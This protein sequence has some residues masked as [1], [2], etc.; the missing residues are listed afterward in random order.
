MLK[1]YFSIT[2][3]GIIYGNAITA[4]AGFLLAS[5][6]NV[7]ILK[8]TATVIGISLVIGSACVFNNILDKEIDKKMERT[9][10]RTLVKGEISDKNAFVYGLILGVIGFLT[11]GISTNNIVVLIGLFAFIDYVILY[12]FSKR[13]SVHGT[14]IGSL[15]GSAPIVAGYCAVSGSIDETALILFAILTAWQM[16]HFY[17]IAIYR[18]NDYKKA[19]IPVLP[20]VRSIKVTKIYIIFYILTFILFTILLRFTGTV[21]NYFFVIITILGLGW[22]LLALSGF[23]KA[24][25]LWSRYMFYYSLM[26]LMIFSIMIS[27]EY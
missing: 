19:N 11:L 13:N 27:F 2:K 8:L 4:I 23:K 25:K 5:K 1:S 18:L 22:L 17:S 20:A 24:K 12:G 14:L 10:N 3:P 9:K 21:N 6:G 7:N 16:P 15:A 26:I